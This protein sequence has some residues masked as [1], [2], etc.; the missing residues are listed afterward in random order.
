[1]DQTQSDASSNAGHAREVR[2]HRMQLLVQ[3]GLQKTQAAA[4]TKETIDGGMQ[5]IFA[6]MRAMEAAVKACPPA[7]IAWVGVCFG[8]EVCLSSSGSG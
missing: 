8:L 7:A 1:M 5:A 6:I 4:N 3:Q 2:Q